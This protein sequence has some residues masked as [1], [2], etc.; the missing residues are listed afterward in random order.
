MPIWKT[1]IFL[2]LLHLPLV[3]GSASQATGASLEIKAAPATIRG[4]AIDQSGRLW[5]GTFGKGLW[6]KDGDAI[7]NIFDQNTQ[8]PFPMINNLLI[9]GK[10]LWIATA[11]GGCVCLNTDDKTFTQIKQDSNFLKLHGLA[12]TASGTMLIGSVGSGTATLKD[13]CWL[14]VQQDQPINIAWVNSIIEWNNKIWLGTSTGLYVSDSD[15]GKWKPQSAS[16]CRGVNHLLVYDNRLFIATTSHGVYQ[17]T[18]GEAPEQIY[19][20]FGAV[21]SLVSFENKVFAMGDDSFWCISGTTANEIPVPFSN[22]KCAAV[23]TKK[24]LLIGTMDGKI[25]RSKNGTDYQ[26]A[27]EFKGNGFEELVNEGN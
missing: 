7:V 2:L 24:T 12:R 4:L 8:Q 22:A 20:T 6:C 21:Y 16:L 15:L 11:G 10:N 17:L 25:Y 26:S 14:P 19:G 13:N 3:F 18:A 1:I 27:I 9:N 23:D 5:I